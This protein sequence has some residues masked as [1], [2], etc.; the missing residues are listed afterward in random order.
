MFQ[1]LG[2][3]CNHLDVR[4]RNY[5]LFKNARKVLELDALL[6]RNCNLKKLVEMEDEEITDK[7]N[8]SKKYPELEEGD[9][10][11]RKDEASI[12]LEFSSLLPG[13]IG[14]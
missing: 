11:D 8:V 5:I 7:E 10:S 6:G 3:G 1:S 14:L 13:V 9:E 2:V 12:S 4:N